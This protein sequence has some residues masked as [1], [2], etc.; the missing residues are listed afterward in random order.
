MPPQM[1]TQELYDLLKARPRR[2]TLPKG[3][4]ATHPDVLRQE[5]DAI[6]RW[7]EEYETA[8]S[9]YKLGGQG[10]GSGGAFG[11]AVTAADKSRAEATLDMALCFA[12]DNEWFQCRSY[13]LQ[14]IDHYEQAILKPSSQAYGLLAVARYMIEGNTPALRNYLEEVIVHKIDTAGL[15][16]LLAKYY[17]MVRDYDAVRRLLAD[18]KL[19]NHYRVI[20][21]RRALEAKAGKAWD[22]YPCNFYTYRDHRLNSLIT[23]DIIEQRKL[24]L[25]KMSPSD[26][27]TIAQSEAAADLLIERIIMTLDCHRLWNTANQAFARKNY[28]QATNYYLEASD[29]ITGYFT[30]YYATADPAKLLHYNQTWERDGTKYESNKWLITY[31]RD[32]NRALS[33]QELYNLD[34][35]RPHRSPEGWDAYGSNLDMLKT[36]GWQGKWVEKVDGPLAVMLFNFL[37]MAI[38]E[39]GLARRRFEDSDEA[40]GLGV[41]SGPL[42]SIKLALQYHDKHRIMSEFIEVPFATMLKARILLLKAEFQYK[43]RE[44]DPSPD[45][46]PATG[47]LRYQGLKAGRT[48]QGVID[49]FYQTG[50]RDYMVNVQAAGDKLKKTIADLRSAALD[51]HVVQMARQINYPALIP[52][53]DLTKNQQALQQLGHDPRI[54]GLVS[55]NSNLL[56]ISKGRHTPYDRLIR[57][58]MD[59]LLPRESNPQIYALIAQAQARLHQLDSGLNWLG[60]RDDYV[61]PWRFQYLLERARYFAGHASQVQNLY[62]T[63]LSTAEKEEAQE[64]TIGQNAIIELAN[65][66]LETSRLK[67]SNLQFA[68]AQASTQLAKLMA[69]NAKTRYSNYLSFD[70]EMDRLTE[71]YMGHALSSSISNVVTSSL[72]G[73]QSGFSMGGW[74]GAIVGAVAGVGIGSWQ[75][76]DQYSMQDISLEMQNQQRELEK[77]N[78]ILAAREATESVKVTQAQEAAAAASVDVAALQRVVALMRHEF[79]LQTVEFMKNRTF[80]S[81]LWYRLASEIKGVAETYLKYGVELAFLAEQAFEFESNRRVDV[82]RFD[83][84]LQE[85]GDFLAGDFL[86]RDLNYLEQELITGEIERRRLVRYTVSLARDFPDALQQL[87]N[88]GW[89]VLH[90]TLLPLEQR[91]PGLFNLRVSSVDIHPVALMDPTRFSVNLTHLGASSIRVRSD[92]TAPEDPFNKTDM[93][94]WTAASDTALD[95]DWPVKVRAASPQTEIYTGVTRQDQTAGDSFFSN[96]QQTAFEGLGAASAWRLDMSMRENRV[97]PTTLADI[98]LVFHFSGYFSEELKNRVQACIPS[99]STQTLLLS[100][101]QYFPNGY[102]HLQNSG[103]MTWSVNKR[104]IP[105]GLQAGRLRNI[106]LSLLPS[107]DR[108][109]FGRLLSVQRVRIK[110]DSRTGNLDVL[111]LLPRFSFET[112]RLTLRATVVF[113]QQVTQVMWDFGDH[114]GWQ[115]TNADGAAYPLYSQ[116]HCYTKAGAYVVTLRAVVSGQL[117]EYTAKV[118]VSGDEDLSSPLTPALTF[119]AKAIPEISSDQFQLVINSGLPSGVQ[120]T[121]S[122]KSGSLRAGGTASCFLTLPKDRECELLCI[123][124]RNLAV[125]F[126]GT[127]CY[128]PTAAELTLP[129][130]RTATNREFDEQGSLKPGTANDLSRRVFGNGEHSPID[131]WQ[132]TITAA[133]N[134]FLKVVDSTG[135]EIMDLSE[136]EDAVLALE[137]EAE[138]ITMY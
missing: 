75:A 62:L 110:F 119:T 35:V 105:T 25:L 125:H 42:S 84:D 21:I 132:L 56:G 80:T 57:F 135:R 102:Y 73:M 46:D 120:A 122:V 39:C 72:Q 36:I 77:K 106:G 104:F 97:D 50:Y 115:P 71:E 81:E 107:S 41:R 54:P 129:G 130:L 7:L 26:K 95:Q 67:Q 33:L 48:Y 34:W 137:Y 52:G 13:A 112:A 124:I 2:R 32:R 68:A 58:D 121:L 136:I 70:E 108:P 76:Y 59:G 20:P 40:P 82:I 123:A 55:F 28:I 69:Q 37:P 85:T 91:F 9:T 87:R 29:K 22:R 43:A 44:N 49:T 51:A 60:Y 128:D 83:Y 64:K 88:N 111:S 14:A 27:K 17:L 12:K 4:P 74:I 16:S 93:P 89:C 78:L 24:E 1:T 133:N 94:S 96:N 92:K 30:A 6:R 126:S 65:V 109:Q 101:H 116:E 134:P 11:A 5:R 127:Q 61:S 10:G 53:N 114:S 47:Q 15:R 19:W 38:A 45:K 31:I 99:R 79:A 118:S 18:P 86:L 98:V 103:T 3:E 66:D 100:G 63:F 113:N 23:N 8:I 138:E 117:Y 131:N 90:L